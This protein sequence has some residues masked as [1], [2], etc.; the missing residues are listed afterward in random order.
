MFNVTFATI[1]ENLGPDFALRIINAA[2]QESDYLLTRYLPE[3][4]R[5]S[6]SVKGGNIRIVPTMAG[7]TGMD[8]P[9]PPGGQIS[10]S[11]FL[12]ETGKVAN[13]MTLTEEVLREMQE[14]MIRNQ[15]QG[16]SNKEYV[17]E[18]IL[19]FTDKV[20][21]QSHRDTFEWLRGQ[22]LANGAINWSYGDITLNVDYQIDSERM[23]STRT[24]TSGE[25]YGE[26][27]SL[28][29]EDRRKAH[30]LLDGQIEEEV[31][32]IDTFYEIAENPANNIEILSD[33][34]QTFRIRKLVGNNERP[35]T[36]SRETASIRTYSKEGSIIDASNP[37][38][39]QNVPFFPRGKVLYVGSADQSG[40]DISNVG[41]GATPDE[42][43]RE[44]GY[45]HIAPTT[46]GMGQLGRWLRVFTPEQR[47]MQLKGEGVTNGLPVVSEDAQLAVASTEMAA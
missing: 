37:E 35:T 8:S 10:V 42:D 6:Y 44:L 1:L 40:F 41:E 13:T 7:L 19:N 27:S 30:R 24:T 17:A 15:A 29:W 39:T 38:Q 25:A 46:E 22:A 4:R 47:P 14:I 33:T 21:L 23:F 11:K 32:H 16:Q 3:R 18:V 45:T 28:Y 36:D 34:D 26:S 43:G 31:M 5:T 9:Y 12:A 2:R 20:L